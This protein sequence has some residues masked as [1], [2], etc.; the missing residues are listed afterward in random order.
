MGKIL[1]NITD[2]SINTIY[3]YTS[4]LENVFIAQVKGMIT[5][6]FSYFYMK[7]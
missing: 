4:L 2:V 6:H 3:G 1:D 7:T 5:Q